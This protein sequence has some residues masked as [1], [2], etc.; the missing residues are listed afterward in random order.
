M[1]TVTPAVLWFAFSA[2]AATFFA[3]CSYPLLPGYV[4]YYVGDADGAERSV[5]RRLRRAAV[6]G[7]SVSVGL[8]LVFVCLGAAILTAGGRLTEHAVTIELVVGSV[9]IVLGLRMAAGGSGS[10]FTSTSPFT[11]PSIQLPARR[12]SIVGYVLFGVV[13][14]A[15][16]AGCTV[17]LLIGLSG[18]ALRTGSIGAIAVIGTYVGGLCA[19][20]ITITLLA[21]LGRIAILRRISR[22]TGRIRRASGLLLIGAG[23]AQLYLF[24]FRYD[25]AAALGLG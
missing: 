2:G 7:I 14:G 18:F 8:A 22:Q 24:F 20:M 21:A 9:V 6:V 19:L 4:A 1:T 13:Y 11:P 15:A 10:A 23:A 16:A 5:G 3:P 12:R 25:G 17:P